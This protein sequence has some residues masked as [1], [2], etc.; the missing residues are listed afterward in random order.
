MPILSADHYWKVRA[1]SQGL[2]T[3]QRE[4]DRALND[5]A[6]KVKAAMVDAGLDPAVNY[7]LNDVDCSAT[8]ATS[9]PP[10]A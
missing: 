7:Q 2:A 5:I 1:L 6:A 9:D 8:P 10:A 3:S 4:A